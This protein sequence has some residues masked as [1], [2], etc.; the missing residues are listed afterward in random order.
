MELCTSQLKP[1]ETKKDAPKKSLMFPEMELSS[2]NI[3]KIQKK[4]FLIFSLKK[5]FLIF[6]EMEPYTFKPELEK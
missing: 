2:S 3:K 1:K 4:A 5:A 6:P